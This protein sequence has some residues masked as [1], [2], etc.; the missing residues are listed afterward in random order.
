MMRIELEILGD[1]GFL[2]QDMYTTLAQ[3]DDINSARGDGDWNDFHNC[4]N[5]D[6]VMQTIGVNYKMPGDIDLQTGLMFPPTQTEIESNIFFNGVYQVNKVESRVNNGQF[7]QILYCT[8]L[9][10]QTGKGD[11]P[12][13]NWVYNQTVKEFGIETKTDDAVESIKDSV[14]KGMVN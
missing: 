5:V 7:T 1:P 6:S 13:K 9:N 12:E 8:R 4:F 2:S 14:E 11:A 10:Q 3:G